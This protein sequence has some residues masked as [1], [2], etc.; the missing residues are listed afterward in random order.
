MGCLVAYRGLGI[1]FVCGADPGDE[2]RLT[3]AH[4][5][6]HFLRDYLLPREEIIRAL[7]DGIV[8]VLDGKRPP[9]LAERTIAVL[10]HLRVGAHIHL[11][12]RVDK[13]EDSDPVVSA[14]EDRADSL[15]LEL[16][17]PRESVLS[18][19]RAARKSGRAPASVC[20]DLA[21]YFGAPEHAFR[22][23][24]EPA[25]NACTVSFLEDIRP[26]LEGRH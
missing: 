9:T 18:L 16:I 15:G 17:A 22:R 3:V 1:A 20:A 12:P 23:F 8:D 19:L 21:A 24:L 13:D 14:A 26:A 25:V 11:L 5:T 4:E 6:S 10:A 2:Q 7:G